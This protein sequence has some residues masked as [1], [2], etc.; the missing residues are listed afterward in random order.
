MTTKEA[1]KDYNA[2][3]FCS[4]SVLDGYQLVARPGHPASYPGIADDYE[5]SFRIW[6]SLPCDVFLGAHGQFFNLTEK[7]EALK[8]GAQENPFIDPSGYQDYVAQKEVDFRKELDR[9][10]AVHNASGDQ[11]LPRK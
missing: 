6:K 11:S 10:K 4:A 8:N 3:F 9:Q 5:K 7:R 1:G 2:V